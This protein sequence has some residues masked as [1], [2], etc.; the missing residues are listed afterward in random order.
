MPFNGTTHLVEAIWAFVD[1]YDPGDPALR[2]GFDQFL[3]DLIASINSQSAYVQ[4]LIGSNPDT[5][6]L[7][8]V[9]TVPTQRADSSA[10]QAGDW[11]IS[12]AAP[13]GR[14]NL[15]YVYDG[16][17]FIVMS[18]F[19]TAGATG[20]SLVASATQAAARG[21]LGLGSAALQADTAFAPSS[22]AT[23]V[24]LALKLADT[25][26]LAKTVT[27]SDWDNAH[28]TGPG[29]SFIQGNAATLN[30]PAAVNLS[31]VYVAYDASNGFVALTDHA[32]GRSY[33]RFRVASGWGNWLEEI[34][35]PI[36][37]TRGSLLLR[38]ATAWAPLG[39]GAAGRH[40]V[41]NGTDLVYSPAFAYTD[42]T[43]SRA[44]NT[45]YTNTGNRPILVLVNIS[46]TAANTNTTLTVDGVELSKFFLGNSLSGLS[47]THSVIVPAG[48]VYQLTR[49]AG[50]TSISSWREAAI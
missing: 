16:G 25:D 22:V 8:R 37:A 3:A 14:V 20:I 5:R 45:N 7:G 10:L 44:I 17:V 2:S 12:S 15:P 31:G 30:G 36:T 11:Y 13:A 4:T 26:G 42:V 33:C 50:N 21:V 28:S 39:L 41:S 29:T 49:S 43:G 35:A 9:A 6:F 24:A 18:D 23:A 27:G 38:G 46:Y 48:G 47:I 1:Q 19:G 40:L 34:S 32:N